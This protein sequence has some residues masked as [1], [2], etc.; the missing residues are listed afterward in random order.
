MYQG[1]LYLD[2]SVFIF[3]SQ[4]YDYIRY[5]TSIY[6]IY[7]RNTPCDVSLYIFCELIKA[8]SY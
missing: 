8:G 4:H 7:T 6:V 2:Q 5:H 1:K 3:Y